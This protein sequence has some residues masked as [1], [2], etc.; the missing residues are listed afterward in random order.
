MVVLWKGARA[1]RNRCPG[2][3][4]PMRNADYMTRLQTGRIRYSRPHAFFTKWKWRKPVRLSCMV[5][6]SRH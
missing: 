6:M 4:I 3:Y 2:D 5:T 1:N